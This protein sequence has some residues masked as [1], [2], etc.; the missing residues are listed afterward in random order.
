ME[1][2]VDEGNGLWRQ[3]FGAGEGE[4]EALRA[5]HAGPY[6]TDIPN[7]PTG[8]SLLHRLRSVAS[9]WFVGEQ[10]LRRQWRDVSFA[11][12]YVTVLDEPGAEAVE[13]IFAG[14]PDPVCTMFQHDSEA[15][16]FPKVSPK[17]PAG[18][19][20]PF[21]KRFLADVADVVQTQMLREDGT[22]TETTF[23]FGQTDE[24][25]A[26]SKNVVS[27]AIAKWR[28][29]GTKV[30]TNTSLGDKG[31]TTIDDVNEGWQRSLRE[32]H[33]YS[34]RGILSAAS[35]EWNT[36]RVSVEGPMKTSPYNEGGP[37]YLL[38]I[39]YGTFFATDRERHRLSR[40]T[41]APEIVFEYRFD[42]SH[43]VRAPLHGQAGA[44]EGDLPRRLPP[45]LGPPQVS[46][47]RLLAH[48]AR[49]EYYPP[50]PEIKTGLAAVS[51]K[52]ERAAYLGA[53]PAER[54]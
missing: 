35:H 9:H 30:S 37:T 32:G 49:S 43:L 2:D 24:F 54:L 25:H 13:T 28:W 50:G 31:F 12:R 53:A 1:T 34:F 45:R 52:W 16:C 26:E 39:S 7:L 20:E 51:I 47:F 19:P 5:L 33:Q 8:E 14:G 36:R 4:E 3:L 27:S 17:F 11:N 23:Y 29:A 22:E 10:S 6:R 21:A 15:L 40:C 38:K 18:A 42:Y 48:P 44:L 46:G 41:E